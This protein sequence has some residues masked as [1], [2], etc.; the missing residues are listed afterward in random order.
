[1]LAELEQAEL[2]KSY[3]V[4]GKPYLQMRTWENHQ[5]I[6]NH[7]SKYPSPDESDC[8][9]LK[10]FDINCNQLQSND[11]K[12]HRNPIQS[13]SLS[14]SESVSLFDNDD[15]AHR[16]VS[17]QNEVLNAAESAGFARSEAMRAKLIDLYAIHGKDK[18]LAAMDECVIHGVTN[19][20]YLSAV[21]KGEPKKKQQKLAVVPAQDYGQRDYS[22]ETEA[23]IER[24][25]EGWAK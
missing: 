20:A 21:L 1:M 2:I 15:D 23:A 9:Q 4:D 10:S 24:M 25:M 19:I 13:E 14:E 7:K 16:I 3:V 17:E 5:Q 11:N 8:N 6:R 18:L 12:C 22:G